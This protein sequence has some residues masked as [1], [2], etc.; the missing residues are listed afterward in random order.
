MVVSTYQRIVFFSAVKNGSFSSKKMFLLVINTI[1]IIFTQ[2][3]SFSVRTTSQPLKKMNQY[4]V[5]INRVG[6][7]E[8]LYKISRETVRKLFDISFDKPSSPLSNSEN[9]SFVSCSLLE[10]VNFENLCIISPF[11]LYLVTN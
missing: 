6:L 5:V 8:T 9:P 2:R 1:S 4:R 7:C 11:Q 3:Y 10:L